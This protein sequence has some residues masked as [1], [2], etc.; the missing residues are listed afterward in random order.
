MELYVT[1]TYRLHELHI[2]AQ[3]WYVTTTYPKYKLKRYMS[4]NEIMS[5]LVFSF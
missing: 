5:L 2:C 3:G 1:T 4:V